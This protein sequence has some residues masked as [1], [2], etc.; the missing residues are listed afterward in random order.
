MGNPDAWATPIPIDYTHRGWYRIWEEG[1]P[2][3][4]KLNVRNV[5]QNS[6]QLM[7]PLNRYQ[8]NTDPVDEY[9]IE[10]RMF[11]AFCKR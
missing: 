5:V 7:Y 4:T 11:P 2:G 10:A 3:L 9:S 8:E 1:F 6:G